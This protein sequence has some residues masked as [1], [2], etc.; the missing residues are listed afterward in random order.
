[1]RVRTKALLLL[2]VAVAALYGARE[3]AKLQERLGQERERSAAMLELAQK[4][5]SLR[6][7]SAG[8]QKLERE[9]AALARPQRRETPDGVELRFEGLDPTKAR[10]LV[11]RLLRSGAPIESLE[12]EKSQKGCSVRVEVGR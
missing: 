6:D 10:Q 7:R 9:L 11:G 8:A 1:M 12:I 3:W 4:I 5:V 2:L